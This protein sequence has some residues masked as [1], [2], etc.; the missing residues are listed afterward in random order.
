MEDT[1]F[2]TLWPLV[3]APCRWRCRRGW[4][5]PRLGRWIHFSLCGSATWL[6]RVSEKKAGESFTLSQKRSWFSGKPT[7]N[8]RKRQKKREP[9]FHW[10]MIMGGRVWLNVTVAVSCLVL[11]IFPKPILKKQVEECWTDICSIYIYIWSMAMDQWIHGICKLLDAYELVFKVINSV[12][13]DHFVPMCSLHGC[14][15]WR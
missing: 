10:T 3:H 12:S 8:E 1:I 9:I 13:S 14:L 4:R 2:E 5:T 11:G 15:K 6:D 7:P